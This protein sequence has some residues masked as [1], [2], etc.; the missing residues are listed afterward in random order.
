MKFLW[1]IVVPVLGACSL[2]LGQ[3][4]TAQDDG[5]VVPV[6]W[7]SCNFRDG[8]D[9]EDLDKVNA[10]FNKWADKNDS[11]YSA[12]LMFPNLHSGVEF[13]LGW[14]G[15]WPSGAD[16]GKGMD[17]FMQSPELMD[18]FNEVVDCSIGHGMAS[19]AVIN[20]PDG[21]PDNGVVIFSSCT[22]KEG[23]S[24]DDSFGAH[25]AMSEAM[26]GMGSKGASWLF[27]PGLGSNVDFD[28]WQVIAFKNYSDLGLTTEMYTNGGGWKKAAEILGPVVSC[29]GTSVWDARLVRA[30]TTR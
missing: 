2:L 18:A 23:K 28:Y 14:L 30:G 10:R 17:A 6:E 15:S 8:K 4:A 26:Q 29:G 25:K 1:K 19:S 13:D 24:F 27:Y 7:F 3:A 16:F 20:A 21:P 12:W 9:L 5:A 22:H 11:G